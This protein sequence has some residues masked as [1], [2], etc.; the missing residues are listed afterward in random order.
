MTYEKKEEKKDT[1]ETPKMV[2]LEGKEITQADLTDEELE[3]VSGGGNNC[4]TGTSQ[5]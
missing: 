3:G 5:V 1:F 4:H 2:D